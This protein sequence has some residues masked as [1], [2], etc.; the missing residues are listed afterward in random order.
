MSGHHGGA[1]SGAGR[2]P[3]GKVLHGPSSQSPQ[4]FSGPSLSVPGIPGTSNRISPFFGAAA[5]ASNHPQD[6][7]GVMQG[8]VGS[9]ILPGASEILPKK[10]F[11]LF[12][13]CV[14][15]PLLT[16]M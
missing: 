10:N 2:H 16:T 1:R 3:K 7:S 9:E 11:K 6:L 13:G 8:S 12:L 15:V 14:K 4:I 5:S